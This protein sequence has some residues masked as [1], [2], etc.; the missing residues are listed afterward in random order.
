MRA[1]LRFPGGDV[2][3]PNLLAQTEVDARFKA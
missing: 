2:L 3:A 1:A